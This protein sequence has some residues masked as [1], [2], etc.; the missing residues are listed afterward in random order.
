M[1][2]KPEGASAS[3]S[4][5]DLLDWTVKR[6]PWL[7]PL[8]AVLSLTFVIVPSAAQKGY[9]DV[10]GTAATFDGE[11]AAPF[12]ER[13]PSPRQDLWAEIFLAASA[14]TWWIA[15][16]F[17]GFVAFLLS[18]YRFLQGQAP[19]H[20][21]P[22]RLAG[23]IFIAGCFLQL[24]L[25]TWS[26]PY[27][28]AP[29]QLE[30]LGQRLLT[31]QEFYE[32]QQA[33]WRGVGNSQTKALYSWLHG[34][35]PEH[36]RTSITPDWRQR[37]HV[38]DYFSTLAR[39]TFYGFLLLLAWS[40]LAGGLLAGRRLNSAAPLL[41]ASAL[42]LPFLVLLTNATQWI[43]LAEDYGRLVVA[44]AFLISVASPK[45]AARFP[46]STSRSTS[47]PQDRTAI[48]CPTSVSL[49]ITN[50]WPVPPLSR[51]N[52]AFRIEDERERYVTLVDGSTVDKEVTWFIPGEC[53]HTY[54]MCD[55]FE[56]NG[57]CNVK[58]GTY[59]PKNNPSR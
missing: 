23:L 52:T 20:R 13:S 12:S 16:V 45:D 56:K 29:Q 2:E 57:R 28:V 36:G 41:V 25:F 44:P 10:I 37:K 24:A 35:D 59:V 17:L 31:P 54:Y 27:F 49:E 53:D 14:N 43:W 19:L 58:V 18:V 34:V 48:E 55:S 50:L 7:L 8:L 5:K 26:A 32:R 9:D 39:W 21:H 22:A 47:V 15:T 33:A 1:P 40:S 4:L 30:E 51:D 42:L 11:P 38:A 6:A 46:F 3:A